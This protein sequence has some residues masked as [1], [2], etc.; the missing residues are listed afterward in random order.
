MIELTHTEKAL[1]ADMVH[2]R[3]IDVQNRQKR[4]AHFFDDDVKPLKTAYNNELANIESL[5][6]KLNI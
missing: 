1:L 6:K 5:R 4:I 2:A 3:I